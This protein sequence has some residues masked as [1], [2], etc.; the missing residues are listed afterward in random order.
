MTWE[1]DIKMEYFLLLL[2]HLKIIAPLHG[3][4]YFIPYILPACSTQQQDEVLLQYGELQGDSLLVQFQSG[5]LLRGLFCCLVVH[6]L[7]SPLLDWK[8]HFSE[9]DD[10]HV[11]SNLITFSIQNA[12][13]LILLDKVSYLEIQIRHNLISFATTS[14]VAVHP[15]VYGKIMKALSAVCDQLNFDFQRV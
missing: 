10:Y 8:L 11:F 12:F 7:Q 4:E 6:L 1:G 2:A 13:F 15:D 5:L 3:D 9:G 14:A